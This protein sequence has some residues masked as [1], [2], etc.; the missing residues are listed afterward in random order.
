MTL[1]FMSS[2]ESAND[3]DEE[4]ENFMIKPIPWRSEKLNDFFRNKLDPVTSNKKGKRMRQLVLRVPQQSG[5]LLFAVTKIVCGPYTALC[6][7]CLSSL[8]LD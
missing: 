2:E 7:P 4:N 1:D 3:S 6:T 5:Q 8:L